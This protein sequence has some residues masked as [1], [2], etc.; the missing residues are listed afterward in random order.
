MGKTDPALSEQLPNSIAI[1]GDAGKEIGISNPGYYGIDVLPQ[2]YVGSFY[3]M[4]TYSS[5]FTAAL[6][7]ANNGKIIASAVVPSSS[8]AGSWTKHE[9]TI[10]STVDAGTNII[11]TLTYVNDPA[12]TLNFNLISLFPPTYNDQPNGMRK[13]LMQTLLDLKPSFFRVP[14]GNNIEGVTYGNEWKW[15]NTIGDMKNRAGRAGTWG[16]FNTD[17]LG[18]I[19]YMIVSILARHG[20]LGAG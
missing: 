7:D 6:R 4:G 3:S 10:E 13:D 5:N 14:G 19:E 16:Y 20:F 15:Q 9:Y 11:F 8:V 2:K 18:L 17:G 12:V 1:K